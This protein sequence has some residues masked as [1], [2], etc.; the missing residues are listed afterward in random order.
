[1]LTMFYQHAS[2]AREMQSKLMSNTD[3]KE[4]EDGRCP[5]FP[6]HTLSHLERNESKLTDRQ[7]YRDTVSR[8]ITSSK[9]FF[10]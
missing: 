2:E 9:V 8:F 10:R 1:M 6:M 3:D 7:V 4:N 5:K